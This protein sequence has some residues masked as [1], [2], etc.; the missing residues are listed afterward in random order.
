MQY[1]CSRFAVLLQSACSTI[2]VALRSFRA[3][4]KFCIQVPRIAGSATILGEAMVSPETPTARPTSDMV[5]PAWRPVSN[6]DRLGHGGCGTRR[7]RASHPPALKC[8]SFEPVTQV[9]R[10]R[11]RKKLRQ[12]PM[13]ARVSAHRHY[14][15]A[16]CSNDARWRR[17]LAQ[18]YGQMLAQGSRRPGVHRGWDIDCPIPP[19]T[20]PASAMYNLI[21]LSKR[22]S[23]VKLQLR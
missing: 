4:R 19:R 20:D 7:C 15:S 3:C 22:A 13:L 21:M 1:L 12:E 8:A 2:A 6:G 23:T 5:A 16:S 18:K 14:R 11:A 10:V 9:F 17:R